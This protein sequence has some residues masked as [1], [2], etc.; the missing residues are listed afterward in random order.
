MDQAGCR[1]GIYEGRCKCTT[2]M[3]P[4]GRFI[5]PSCRMRRPCRDGRLSGSSSSQ[6]LVESRPNVCANGDGSAHQCDGQRGHQKPCGCP[7]GDR[8]GCASSGPPPPGCAT[9]ALARF[10]GSIRPG[11]EPELGGSSQCPNV[12]FVWTRSSLDGWG[13]PPACTVG[14]DVVRRVGKGGKFQRKDWVMSVTAIK[15]LYSTG[16]HL[17]TRRRRFSGYAETAVGGVVTAAP[18]PIEIRK[19]CNIANR[20]SW[21]PV[22]VATG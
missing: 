8:R 16:R 22:R 3:G 6:R 11:A 18:G 21:G 15:R 13:D 17:K 2:R 10:P 5:P 1:S 7:R 20:G 19:G 9:T 4:G 12:P 14:M